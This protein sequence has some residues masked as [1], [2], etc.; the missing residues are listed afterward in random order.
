MLLKN[1]KMLCKEKGIP[2]SGLERET[3]ISNG[4][5]SRWGTSSPTVE[6]ALKVAEY[7]GITVDQLIKCDLTAKSTEEV[8]V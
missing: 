5:I 8:A 7:F 4:T 6:N 1:I 3:G 2:I